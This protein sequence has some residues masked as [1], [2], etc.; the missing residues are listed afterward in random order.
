MNFL[1]PREGTP[2]EDRELVSPTEAIRTIAPFRLIMPSTTIRYA[3]GR[4][5]TLGDLQA[6]G[7]QS[8]V[9]ALI[10]GNYLTTLGQNV[11]NDL[12]MLEDLKM[13]IKAVRKVL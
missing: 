11:S 1:N 9:N 7:M 12:H 2:L 13:P 5:V 10:P 3:G 8:G 4:E 6:M